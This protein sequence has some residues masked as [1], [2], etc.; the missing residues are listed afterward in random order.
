MRVK[1]NHCINREECSSCKSNDRFIPSDEVKQYFEKDIY[2]GKYCFNPEDSLLKS[3]HVILINGVEYCPYCGEVMFS[4]PD[5]E[6]FETVGHCCI[7]EG[8]RSEIE[9]E[10]K[11]AE[12]EKKFNEELNALEGEYR[13]RLGFCSEKLLDIKQSVERKRF[14]FFSHEYNHFSKINGKAY[15]RIE[16]M[17]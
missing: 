13:S 11:K 16:S 17:L 15:S 12:L 9:F 7:C 6:T 5:K 3:T 14:E 8:A 4:I 10:E 2:S 1:C